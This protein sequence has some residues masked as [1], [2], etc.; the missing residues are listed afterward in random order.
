METDSSTRKLTPEATLQQIISFNSNISHMLQSIGLDPKDSEEKTLRQVCSEKQWNEIELLK[1]IKKNPPAIEKKR[2]L[3]GTTISEIC[4]FLEKET[5]TEIKEL[6]AYVRSDYI[7]TSK[8]H[9][10]QYSWLNSAKW[11]VNQLL[12]TLQYFSNF[13]LETFYPLAIELQKQGKRTL[14]GSVQN[15]KKSIAVVKQDHQIIEERMERITKISRSFYYD[16]S[17]CSTLRILCNRFET[18]FQTIDEHINIEQTK[19][20]PEIEQILAIS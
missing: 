7:L 15:L 8:I 19:L 10:I 11:H 1:W 9:G 20:L 16:E 13:E 14:D 6:S 3:P 5:L 2:R 12:N 18:L 4:S 17:A